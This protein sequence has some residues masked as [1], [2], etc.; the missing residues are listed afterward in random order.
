[1]VEVV[2]IAQWVEGKV[3]G[4]PG[5]IFVR[6][7]AKCRALAEAVSH[8][9]G[10]TVPAV[11]SEVPLALR[12]RYIERLQK[13]DLPCI[14]ATSAMSTGVDIPELRWVAFADKGRAPIWVIQSAGRGSRPAPGKTAFDVFDLVASEAGTR[15]KHLEGY[16]ED[17]EDVVELC[18]RRSQRVESQHTTAAPRGLDLGWLWTI[19]IV[20]A[21][22][23][24]CMMD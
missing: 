17:P 18:R 24:L 5:I 2:K 12:R 8:Q 20:L 9:L 19:V 16:C 15:R 6:T 23:A 14:V 11:T 13:R 7:K 22:Y 21:L 1:M 4:G 10:M 3:P